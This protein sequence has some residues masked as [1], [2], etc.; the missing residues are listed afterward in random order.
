MNEGK[1]GDQIKELENAHTGGIISGSWFDDS[2]FFIT[3]SNDKTLK[4]WTDELKYVK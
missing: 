1:L 4:I 2:K 3:S